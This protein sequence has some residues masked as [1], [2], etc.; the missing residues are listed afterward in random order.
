MFDAALP[1]ERR[2]SSGL[3]TFC[4]TIFLVLEACVLT[5]SVSSL[6]IPAV[7]DSASALPLFCACGRVLV[8]MEGRYM[9]RSVRGGTVGETGQV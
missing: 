4:F 8:C 6:Q 5:F 9:G 7:E 2:H 1:Q 3:P